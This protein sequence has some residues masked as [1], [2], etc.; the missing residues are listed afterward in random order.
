MD[1]AGF[2][3]L[4]ID[5]LGVKSANA[6]ISG[7]TSSGKTTTLNTLTSFIPSNERIITIEDIL[8]LQN[9]WDLCVHSIGYGVQEVIQDCMER[10][11]G[12]YVGDGCYTALCHM[13]MTGDDSM[14]RYLIDSAYLS[15][16][17]VE[18]TVTCLNCSFMQ[19]IAEFPLMLVSLMMWHYRLTEDKEYLKKNYDFAYKLAEIYRKDYEKDGLLQN[20]DK[21]CVVEWPK[22]FRDD[23]DVNLKQGQVC[24]TPHIAINAYYIEMISNL[25]KM[26]EILG[27]APYRDLAELKKCFFK[28]K[29]F[30]WY[31]CND[32]HC[33]YLCC[34]CNLYL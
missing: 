33:Y 12:F 16:S 7:G 32:I 14:V 15:S 23:Y 8:E 24:E 18:S 3:W 4:C 21:W 9:I 28:W 10:E 34:T 17:F 11:K 27:K 2:L 26:A 20:L 5:G 22:N 13:L 25:N 19:E 31:T 29:R 6:I 1:L 30:I